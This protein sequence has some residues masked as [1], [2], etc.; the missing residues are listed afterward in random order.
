M[1]ARRKT[2]TDH[3]V[4][5]VVGEYVGG[6]T[7]PELARKFRVGQNRIVAWVNAAGV[8]RKRGAATPSRRTMLAKRAEAMLDLAESG[9][10]LTAVAL[11]HGIPYSTLTT[12]VDAERDLA[13]EGQWVVVGGIQRPVPRAS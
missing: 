2:F 6:M 7:V 12:W 8:A 3:E 5:L 10:S 4:A 1:S 9:D 11:R 13:Y